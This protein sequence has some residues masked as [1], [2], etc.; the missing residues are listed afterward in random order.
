MIVGSRIPAWIR[1]SEHNV[2]SVT[3]SVTS[4]RTR[5]SALVTHGEYGCGSCRGGALL[6]VSMLSTC[7]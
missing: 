5:C 7:L 6:G 2:T 3:S 1:L 4:P